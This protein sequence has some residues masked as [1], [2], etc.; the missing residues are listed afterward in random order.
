MRNIRQRQ[1]IKL[2]TRRTPTQKPTDSKTK[3]VESYRFSWNRLTDR[4]RTKFRTLNGSEPKDKVLNDRTDVVTYSMLPGDIAFTWTHPDDCPQSYKDARVIYTT[5]IFKRTEEYVCWNEYKKFR[6][7]INTESNNLIA[8]VSLNHIPIKF[9][10]KC[11]PTHIHLYA[12]VTFLGFIED[13]VIFKDDDF[14]QRNNVEKKRTTVKVRERGVRKEV[15]EANRG[16]KITNEEFGH[17]TPIGA[18]K[19]TYNYK[20]GRESQRLGTKDALIIFLP[21]YDMRVN[22]LE[23]HKDKWINNFNNSQLPAYK[24]DQ[25][26]RFMYRKFDKS[27]E[28]ADYNQAREIPGTG[29]MATEYIRKRIFAVVKTPCGTRENAYY[30]RFEDFNNLG[31]H[32]NI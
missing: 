32:S 22:N 7:A 3:L 10:Y 23:I 13:T 1:N 9:F 15:N 16:H 28:E 2:A 29:D 12:C 27:Q 11:W 20:N 14:V 25:R 30:K 4:R 26:I 24:N 8:Y 19:P 5:G 31:R 17:H 18:F 6:E 21:A